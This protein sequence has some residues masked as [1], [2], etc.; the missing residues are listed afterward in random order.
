MKEP[1][2]VPELRPQVIAELETF[3]DWGEADFGLSSN[4]GPL[5]ARALSGGGGPTSVNASDDRMAH[6]L[7]L[8][9]EQDKHGNFIDSPVAVQRAVRR[10]LMQVGEP[11]LTVLC[12]RHKYYPWPRDMAVRFGE[13]CGVAVLTPE[14]ERRFQL[15]KTLSKTAP[16]SIELW[17]HAIAQVNDEAHIDAVRDDSERMVRL[18]H[19]VYARLREPGPGERGCGAFRSRERR[20][21]TRRRKS[22]AG[23]FV[24]EGFRP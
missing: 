5:A 17:L 19:Q 1:I 18:A 3:F 7:R 23:L 22:V 11:H 21:A 8:K 12:A 15:A 4:F 20:F 14:A 6:R 2:A 24:P 13:V 9:F 16:P 10:A